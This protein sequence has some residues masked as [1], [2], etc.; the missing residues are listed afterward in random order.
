MLTLDH[1]F[2]WRLSRTGVQYHGTMKAGAVV[3]P[4]YR[5]G[6]RHLGPYDGSAPDGG[7]GRGGYHIGRC[8]DDF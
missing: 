4:S 7:A 1:R 2:S 8:Q 5:C 6:I 3:S